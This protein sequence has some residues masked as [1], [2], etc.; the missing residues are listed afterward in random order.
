M[1]ASEDHRGR[2]SY[3]TRRGAGELVLGSPARPTQ[4]AAKENKKIKKVDCGAQRAKSDSFIQL[5]IKKKHT[6]GC[7]RLIEGSLEA[8]MLYFCQT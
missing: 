4:A 8:L 3:W 7:K 6:Q 2:C 1:S 5:Q